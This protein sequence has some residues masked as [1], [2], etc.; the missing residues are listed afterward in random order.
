[1]DSPKTIKKLKFKFFLYLWKKATFKNKI[2][3]VN[4]FFNNLG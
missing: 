1:M 3:I 2:L 4:V